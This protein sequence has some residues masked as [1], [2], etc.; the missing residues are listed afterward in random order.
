M[1]FR[2][3]LGSMNDAIAAEKNRQSEA[4]KS[5]KEKE[6]EWLQQKRDVL[7]TKH[8]RIYTLWNEH[9]PNVD[10]YLFSEKQCKDASQDVIDK[11]DELLQTPKMPGKR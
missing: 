2:S 9:Y 1:A 7:C 8:R 10:N 6:L 11:I 4:E 3:I 5:T